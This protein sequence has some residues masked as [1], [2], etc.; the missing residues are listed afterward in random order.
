MRIDWRSESSA[1]VLLVIGCIVFGLGSIIVATVPVGAYAIAFWRLLVAGG[2]FLILGRVFH[3]HFPRSAKARYYGLIAGVFL[4]FDLALWHESIYAVGPGISTLLN[5]LQIFWL[6]AIGFIWF[7]ERQTKL[8]LF[9]LVLAV[10]GV[11]LIGSPEFTHN[12]QALWGFIS[13]ITSGLMLALSMVFVR[14]THE[15]EKTQIFPLMLLISLGGMGALIVPALVFDWGKL[16]PT[17][18]THM[19]LIF[20]YG[21]IMQCFAWGLI[22]YAIPLLSLAL[23]GLLLLSEPVAALLID[24]FFLAKPISALQWIGAVFTMIAIYLGSLKAQKVKK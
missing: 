12:E 19:G 24:Y 20:I 6:S 21:A 18:L 3:Q 1:S 23:T 11:G 7:N 17:T 5:S 10:L 13:G 16:F 8:Q 14:K 15:V 4:G 2:I 22:A 9:S